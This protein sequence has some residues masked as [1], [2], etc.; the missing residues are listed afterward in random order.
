MCSTVVLSFCLFFRYLEVGDN[1][2]GCVPGVPSALIIDPGQTSP[3]PRCP[4]GCTN[5]TRYV[6]GDNKCVA[7]PVGYS[8]RGLGDLDCPINIAPCPVT[9]LEPFQC[10]AVTA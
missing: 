4:D 3:T 5:R 8:A 7:C 9:Y 10:T 2:L 6:A 1:P